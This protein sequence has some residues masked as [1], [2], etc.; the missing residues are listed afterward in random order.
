MNIVLLGAPGTGKG[1]QAQFI[2][3]LFK[4]PIISPG[5]ILRQEIKKGTTLGKKAKGFVEGG[6]LVPDEIIVGMIRK[7]IENKGAKNGFILDGFPRNLVQAE[8]LEKMLNDIEM[9]IDKAIYFKME[10]NKI[11]ERLSGRRVCNDCG[12]TYHILYNPPKKDHICDKCGGH[13][14]Q[15][16]DDRPEIIK[17]R[18]STYDRNTA[19]IIDYYR[20]KDYYLAVAAD[21]DISVI[22]DSLRRELGG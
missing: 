5:D 3:E 22:R 18:L 11:I 10:E 19:P 16:E 1:T 20:K 13:L 9:S 12:E 2:A 21:D 4:I 17:K 15:R 14:Y 8:A 6:K 7:R